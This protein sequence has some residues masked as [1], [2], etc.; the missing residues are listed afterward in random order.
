MKVNSSFIATQ[1]VLTACGQQ[2]TAH[3]HADI[4]AA[5]SWDVGGGELP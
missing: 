4:E 1:L 2:D 3:Q 5:C